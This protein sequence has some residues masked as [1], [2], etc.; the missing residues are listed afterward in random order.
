MSYLGW[1]P[2]SLS[3]HIFYSPGAGLVNPIGQ[4]YNPHSTPSRAD[5]DELSNTEAH[6]YPAEASA[7]ASVASYDL[8]RAPTSPGA[9]P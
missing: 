6:A 9:I 1:K 8:V 5:K 2:M 4:S 7:P 3:P